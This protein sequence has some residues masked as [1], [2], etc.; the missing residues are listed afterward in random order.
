MLLLCVF[1]SGVDQSSRCGF[2]HGGCSKH[3][4]N[5][6]LERHVLLM[7]HF[8]ADLSTDPFFESM[9]CELY[10]VHSVGDDDRILAETPIPLPRN[11]EDRLP[12]RTLLRSL[13]WEL[14]WFL[15]TKLWRLVVPFVLIRCVGSR[16]SPTHRAETTTTRLSEGT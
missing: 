14:L 11:L 7:L 15:A 10:G 3:V 4:D 8:F 9:Y 2:D 16:H 1:D 12:K 5:D 13:R 6:G